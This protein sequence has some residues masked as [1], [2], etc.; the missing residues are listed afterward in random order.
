[1]HLLKGE[2]TGTPNDPQLRWFKKGVWG[3]SDFTV[4]HFS[5]NHVFVFDE[6]YL[7][8]LASFSD[9]LLD[10]V[11]VSIGNK[12]GRLLKGGYKPYS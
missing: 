5:W 11:A 2:S 8:V 1:M 12:L 10:T 3:T 6:F 7:I 9:A 4:L